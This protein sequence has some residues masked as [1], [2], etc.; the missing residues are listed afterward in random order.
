MRLHKAH[1]EY[2]PTRLAE[3]EK[4]LRDLQ[5]QE[6]TA[7][8]VKEIEAKKEEVTLLQTALKEW[9]E[10]RFNKLSDFEK[11]IHRKAFVTNTGDADYHQV[12]ELSYDDNGVKR[13][14]KVPKGDVLHQFRKDVNTNELP[15]VSWLVAPSNFSDHPGSPGMVPGIFLR[16][17]IF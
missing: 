6:Q 3:V 12:E 5:Q 13:T 17:L 9:T 4:T 15:L 2:L 7:K 11:N 10:E 14:V 1:R 16:Y 8:V